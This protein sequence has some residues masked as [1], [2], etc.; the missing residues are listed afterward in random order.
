L[1]SHQTKKLKRLSM[2]WM[3]RKSTE[4]VWESTSRVV[5]Q[6]EEQEVRVVSKEASKVATAEEM[7]VKLVSLIL[8]SL[9][10][11]V[12]GPKKIL[13]DNSLLPVVPFH[14][15]ELLWTKKEE[16]RASLTFNSKAP[17]LPRKP[18][19]WMDRNSMEEHADLI[20]Q[21]HPIEVLVVAEVASE[22]AEAS[23][24]AVALAEIE[25]A[26]EVSAVAVDSVVDS[27]ATEAVVVASVE[28]AAV[29]ASVEEVVAM[30]PELTKA[31]LSLPKTRVLSS[32][33]WISP[34]LTPLEF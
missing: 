12:S 6:L 22:V 27:V 4:E 7:V 1:P 9:V 19:F 26:V 17:N 11:S 30:L 10:I 24:A 15:L 31:S 14:K 16:L 29:E 23:V 32:E 33:L 8:F 5:P 13:S 34:S 25:V 21:S 2:D 28:E 20:F 18:S 3:D